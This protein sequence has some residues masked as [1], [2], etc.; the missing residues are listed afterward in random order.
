MGLTER[1]MTNRAGAIVI[2]AALVCSSQAAFV[3]PIARPILRQRDFELSRQ[4]LLRPEIRPGAAG[5]A[6]PGRRPAA[7]ER[8]GR[9]LR[10]SPDDGVRDPGGGGELSTIASP[11]CGPMP[12]GATSRRKISSA[13]PQ[14]STPDLRIMDLMDS[15]PEFTKA[16][17]D[18]LDIL[19][20][21]NRLAK[22]REIL[23]KYKPQFDA[24]EKAYGVDRY[25]VASIWGIE[26]E[27]LDADG[28]PQRG[29]IDRDAGLRR[30]PPGLFQ[31]RIPHRAGNPQPRR[32]ASRTDAR[33]LGR[34]VRA[35]AVHA[36]RLQALRR[37]RRRRRP[38]RRRRQ[39]RRPDRLD[40][41]QP[42]EGRLADRP[43]LGLRG[44]AA[45]GLQFH[46]GG[47]AP[48]R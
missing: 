36:D 12:H 14:V 41:Q 19:V 31:G 47:Q 13:S 22:G 42:Q 37:R 15:Q 10:P 24:V 3:S 34:R 2:A 39:R 16:I 17:W 18:Y 26:F 8:R 6:R 45:G 28:R 11:R 9:R 4:H 40:R 20:N 48:R 44:G 27:L 23:A 38:P 5:R 30:P 46:A 25:I 33:L 7:L 21:D 43:E 35:D 32:S 1:A 29:A